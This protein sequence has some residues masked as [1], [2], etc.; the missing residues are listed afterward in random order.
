MPSFVPVSGATISGL[1]YVYSE[2]PPSAGSNIPVRIGE[3]PDT[4]PLPVSMNFVPK[5]RR[6][7]DTQIP[8]FSNWRTYSYEPITYANVRWRMNPAQLDEF[9]DWWENTI[10]KGVGWFTI[11]L[12]GFKGLVSRTV[13]FITSLTE[14]H[15][16]AG[17][18][19]I[20]A[21]LEIR[22]EFRASL[23][24][25]SRPYPIY[26][27]DSLQTGITFNSSADMYNWL[28]NEGYEVADAEV[29]SAAIYTLLK[30]HIQPVEDQFQYGQQT[31]ITGAV[32]ALLLKHIQPVEDFFQY[33]AQ[34]VITGAVTSLLLT[35]IQP[36]E[37]QWQYGIQNI[38]SGT[39]T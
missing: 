24:F 16:G 19:D 7:S 32:T 21:T 28:F 14:N 8:G 2:P 4:L 23:I 10:F 22:G 30:T 9:N 33:G 37:D 31:V 20:S 13:R 38:V 29:I 18:F 34:N 25:T 27:Q 3:Y 35:H 15:L 36:V 26:F 5:E 6:R 11:T 1:E 17:I 39:L 12:P